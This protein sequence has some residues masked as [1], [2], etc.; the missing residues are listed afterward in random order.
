M[1]DYCIK[2]LGQLYLNL[3]P[4]DHNGLYKNFVSLMD[5]TEGKDRAFI[6]VDST[7]EPI[8]GN[9]WLAVMDNLQ[10]YEDFFKAYKI[11]ITGLIHWYS[12]NAD[13]SGAFWFNEDREVIHKN[14]GYDETFE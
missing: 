9:N 6:L 12:T 13:D 1:D 5:L 7:L 3:S 4:G 8:D 11:N 10:V 14:Y 2:Y